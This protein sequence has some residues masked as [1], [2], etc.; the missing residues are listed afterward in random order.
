MAINQDMKALR[1]KLADIQ[2]LNA[3]A[4]SED[5]VEAWQEWFSKVGAARK[6]L[7]RLLKECCEE[8]AAADAQALSKKID[9]CIGVGAKKLNGILVQSVLGAFPDLLIAEHGFKRLC[10]KMGTHQPAP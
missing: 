3:V 1:S 8:N 10:G 5:A 6:S 2:E 7:S 9:D 4:Q